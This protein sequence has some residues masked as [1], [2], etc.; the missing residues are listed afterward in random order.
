MELILRLLTLMIKSMY[1]KSH[2]YKIQMQKTLKKQLKSKQRNLL[3]KPNRHLL[4]HN[5]R[6]HPVLFKHSKHGVKN[7]YFNTVN[8]VLIT[9][10]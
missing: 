7:L 9:S 2:K 3:V 4:L 6:P 1:T 10:N 8:N 5:L